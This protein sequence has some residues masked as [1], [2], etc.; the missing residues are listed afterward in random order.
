MKNRLLAM[1]LAVAMVFSITCALPVT[2]ESAYR[3]GDVNG[4]SETDIGDAL[5]I[6]KYLADLDNVIDGN[7]EAF[8]AA[9]ITGDEPTIGCVLEILKFLA[10]LESVLDD[11]CD[12]CGFVDCECDDVTD[13]KE[14]SGCGKPEKDCECPGDE[15]V[16]DDCGNP[17]E[18]CDCGKEPTEPTVCPD[19]G[20]EDC[21]CTSPCTDCKKY[22]CE[23]P[24]EPVEP[25][26]DEC[27]EN[28]CECPEP[29]CD[30]CKA[31]RACVCA[32]A[33]PPPAF[34]HDEKNPRRIYIKDNKF[35][36]G[37]DL[38]IWI[39]G[40][41]TPWNNWDEFG[42]NEYDAEWWD[43]HFA[44][45]SAEGVNASRVW[46][47]CRNT[48]RAVTIDARGNVTGVSDKHWQDLDSLF[49]IAQRHEIYVMATI[50]SFDHFK[51]A[52]ANRWRAMVQSAEKI[53][54]YVTHYTIP[55]VERYRDNPYLFS[56]DL[57]NEPDWVHENSECGR[58]AWNDLSHFF[59]RNA[60]AIRE[61][62]E[63]LVTVGM[64]FPKYNADGSGYNGNKVSDE[65]LQNLYNS[66][67][68]Y[69]DYWSP[70]FYNWV[71]GSYGHPFTSKPFGPREEG[72]WGLCDSKPAIIAETSANGSRGR[73]CPI[74]RAT[75]KWPNAP[76]HP[77]CDSIPQYTLIEDY[78]NAYNNGWLGVMAWTS[79]GV[80]PNG[81][82]EEQTPANRHM[83]ELIPELVFPLRFPSGN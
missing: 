10:D 34:K 9:C 3:L 24:D 67:N 71:G 38:P 17:E 68:A 62:S 53:N 50:T 13:P 70:H 16:C 60:A 49:E 8:K 69:I 75:C 74:N 1:L 14:C 45:L 33:E 36:V 81:G 76:C 82:F 79:N 54:D 61:N 5:E 66:P 21:I 83:L 59:A 30:K 11:V 4:D 27:G 20:K 44:A 25:G 52:T 48:Q 58:L 31:V 26:C 51:G 6:L 80:D 78:E 65:F 15:E 73:D 47:N 28:P 77:D 56:I 55:L 46:I 29:V 23:C 22:P 63:I 64:A 12:D 32:P 72:G 37:D 39:N 57:M 18:D 35:M 7:D 19:C 2:A 40:T 41:N 43:E 42:S